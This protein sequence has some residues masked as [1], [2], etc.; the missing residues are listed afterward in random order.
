MNQEEFTQNLS[1]WLDD[2]LE[3]TK[4]APLQQQMADHAGYHDLYQQMKQLDTALH[5]AALQVTTPDVGF[6]ERLELRLT[7]HS[8]KQQRQAWF[9]MTALLLGTA[10][11][12]MFFT[13]EVVDLLGLTS[14]PLSLDI[15]TLQQ[16]QIVLIDWLNNVYSLINLG[17]VVLKASLIIIQQPLF[18]VAAFMSVIVM[19]MWAG[20]MQ[21][22]YRQQSLSLPMLA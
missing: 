15:S 11:L 7:E 19:G 2:E 14:I 22:L 5:E 4:I 18:W 12:L 21:R 3:Q 16:G 10:F 8:L 20:V 1:L 6:A 9:A 17:G 13:Y